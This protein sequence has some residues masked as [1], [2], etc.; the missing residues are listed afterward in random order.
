M[1][2][3]SSWAFVALPFIFWA[4]QPPWEIN[5]TRTVSIA[6]KSV[7]RAKVRLPWLVGAILP[8]SAINRTSFFP[9]VPP[10]QTYKYVFQTGLSG[11][12]MLQLASPLPDR[13]QQGRNRQVRLLHTQRHHAVILAHRF[14]AR[15]RA[16]SLKRRPV[17]T[18]A[19]HKLHDVMPAQALYQVWRRTLGDDLPMIHNRQAITQPLGLIHIMRGQHN[20]A[21]GALKL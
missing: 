10:G 18:P 16:P 7:P 9:Q 3:S 14:H 4:V 5:R 8:S 12:Q 19:H 21:P 17:G 15:Q 11:G 20:S 6:G 2:A 1:S 13:I